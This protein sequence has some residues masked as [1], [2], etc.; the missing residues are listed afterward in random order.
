MM[1]PQVAREAEVTE[2]YHP[3]MQQDDR[4]G[5]PLP[6]GERSP[7]DGNRKFVI[8]GQTVDG[9]AFRPSDWAE[10]LAGVM[11]AFRPGR[12]GSQHHLSY[13]PYVVPSMKDGFR[14]V[15]VDPALRDLEPMAYNFL[16]GFA[17]DNGLRLEP[18]AEDKEVS[19]TR[20]GSKVG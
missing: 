7:G 16:L 4:N 2:G 9:R 19:S 11:A 6:D 13:S 14:C 5:A 1:T 3:A 17:R 8:V 12:V 18:L 15:I 10:R 20:G